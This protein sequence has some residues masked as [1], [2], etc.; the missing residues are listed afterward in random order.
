MKILYV[1]KFF[2]N[3]GGV[4]THFFNLA[5]LMHKK[6]HDIAFFSMI[7]EF[8]ESSIWNIYFVSRVSFNSDSIFDKLKFAVRVIYSSEARKKIAELITNFNPDIVHLHDIHHQLSSS[9]IPEITNKNIPIIQNLGN[10]HLISPNYN[11]FHNGKICEI[12]KKRQFY[13]AIFHKCVKN[14]YS[15]SLIEIIEKYL[16]GLTGW[17]NR[18]ISKF[19]VPSIFLKKKLSEFGINKHKIIYL[20]HFVQKSS[21]IGKKNGNYILYFGRL[22]EEKGLLFLLK[23]MRHLPEIQLKIVGKGEYKSNLE[24]FIQKTRMKNIQIIEHKAGKELNELIANSSFTILP[25]IWYEVFGLS[26]IESF[27]LRKTVIG[28]NIGAIPE[29]IQNNKNGLLFNPGD[30]DDCIYKI[31]ILYNNKNLLR[32]LN[33]SAF[34]SYQKKYSEENYYQK[35]LTI[36]NGLLS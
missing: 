12:S 10:Y 7:D 15:A 17:D 31:R 35:I 27:S 19:I 18:F 9:I 21:I 30:F 25:S 36:Y 4:E 22:S 20:P 2:H 6:G 34:K 13:K 33:Y 32:N 23:V 24:N 26:I 16:N 29:I 11:L 8:C 14:S 1:N 3:F 5:K 28:A